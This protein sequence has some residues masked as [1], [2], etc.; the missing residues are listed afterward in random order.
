MSEPPPTAVPIVRAR[1][2]REWEAL[3][4]ACPS[5]HA[6]LDDAVGPALRCTG[7]GREYPVTLGIPDLRL[8]GDPYLSTAED[9]TAAT[10]LAGRDDGRSF[11]ELY[12]SYYEG[13]AKVPPE[14]V[15]R[16][17]HGVLAAA[18]R[19]QATLQTWKELDAPMPTTGTL[20]DLG[21]GTAPLGVALACSGYSVVGVDAGLRWLVLARKRAAEQGIDLP[22]VCANAEHLPLRAASC[23]AVVGESVLENVADADAVV[24]ESRRVLGPRGV[25]ALTTPNRH[26][27]GPDPH[28]GLLAGGWRSNATLQAHA[29]RSGQVM[30]RRRLFTPAELTRTLRHGGFEDVRLSLPQF[31]GAQVSGLAAPLRLAIGAYHLIRRIPLVR[32]IVLQ[33]APAISVVARST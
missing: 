21:C 29:L 27:V 31:A 13:N 6:P 12:A 5:C 8:L 26:S 19:A 22:V 11:G 4:V 20:L 16:F 3:G 9:V 33:I 15:A 10:T 28:L 25:L 14:Q 23:T 17:T 30:P 2:A 32:S 1:S 18:D 7:C 24:R